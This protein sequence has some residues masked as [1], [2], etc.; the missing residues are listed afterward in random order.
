MKIIMFGGTGLL[1]G[2]LM[3][4]CA[5]RHEIKAL[6]SADA[7]IRDPEAV[8]AI[9]RKNRPDAVIN[10]AAVT[11]VD[12]CEKKPDTA[13]AVNAVGPKNIAITC[14]DYKVKM[15]HIST[16][17]VFDGKKGSAYTEFDAPAPVNIYGRSKLAGEMFVKDILNDYL[18]IRTAWL[19]G[20]GRNHFVDYVVNGIKTQD[21]IIAVEDMVS[22]PTYSFDLAMQIESMLEL[23]QTGVFHAANK[24]YASRVEM[25]EEIMKIMK[26][27]AKLKAV[28]QSQWE[29]PA[30]RPVFSALRNYHLDLIDRDKM[31]GWRDAL[32]RYIRQKFE[33]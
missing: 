25:V 16:D 8:T 20:A 14:R 24:G 4:A 10:C 1:G 17:Y 22:S 21:E 6:G 31:A 9:V 32:K 23:N 12:D 13:F 29:K 30:Q 5:G 28:K 7:D 33:R 27:Q 11:N 19:F 26:K 15:I 2:D 18:I 3:R